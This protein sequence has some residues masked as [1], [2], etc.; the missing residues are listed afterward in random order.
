MK[1]FAYLTLLITF[2]IGLG[3]A[4][5]ASASATSPYVRNDLRHHLIKNGT[6]TNWAGYAIETNLK[7]PQS[8]AVSEVS[9]QWVVPTVVCPIRSTSYSSSWVGIDG[10]SD[11]TVEQAGTEQDCQRGQATYYA[12]YEFYPQAE[13]SINTI[14]VHP[15]DSM[16]GDVKYT[17]TNTFTVTVSDLT[18]KQSFSV[19]RRTFGAERQS[20]EWIT[21]APSSWVGV[22]PLA[23]FGTMG[24]TNALA[25]VNNHSGTISDPAWQNDPV[26]MLVSANGPAKATVSPLSTDGSSFTATW[27]HN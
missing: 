20:A 6:S 2:V 18:T 9:G 11:S 8:N 19:S 16:S 15:G 5:S 12:W 3:S 13:L 22:L 7:S 14:K 27:Q 26:T 17:T 24:F 1:R 23:D 10:Y 25:T 4:T 21:E